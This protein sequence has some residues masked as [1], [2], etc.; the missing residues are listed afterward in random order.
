MFAPKKN[1]RQPKQTRIFSTA[2]RNQ[3]ATVKR[4]DITSLNNLRMTTNHLEIQ[5]QLFLSLTTTL[6]FAGVYQR[7]KNLHFIISP[8]IKLVGLFF[9]FHEIQSSNICSV[10]LF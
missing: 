7:V 1:L 9:K 2:A 10:S 8:P 4:S 5:E 6:D 3:Q